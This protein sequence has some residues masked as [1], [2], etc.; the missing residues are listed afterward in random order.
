M[1]GDVAQNDG[2]EGHAIRHCLVLAAI[3]VA[4]RRVA[5]SSSLEHEPTN[6][7]GSAA[8]SLGVSR[9]SARVQTGC[10]SWHWPQVS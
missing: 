1:L 3:Y 4:I 2:K 9:A 8:P 5:G 10:V 7:R 6:Y